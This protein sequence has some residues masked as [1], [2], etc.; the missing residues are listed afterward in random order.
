MLV[1]WLNHGE[2]LY[3]FDAPVDM[4]W[5]YHWP[6]VNRGLCYLTLEPWDK[7]TGEGVEVGYCRGLAK[8]PILC[9][10]IRSMVDSFLQK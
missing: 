2:R 8:L 5:R 9:V 6:A 7:V 3:L 10:K 1:V 4:K